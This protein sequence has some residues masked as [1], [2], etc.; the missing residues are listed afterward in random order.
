MGYKESGEHDVR[1]HTRVECGGCRSGQ[2]FYA[3]VGV[4]WAETMIYQAAGQSHPMVH[5]T[6]CR[7]DELVRTEN[8]PTVIGSFRMKTLTRIDDD[9]VA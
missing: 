4:L 2:T 3:P 8:R 7:W 5:N 1:H 9:R 6:L